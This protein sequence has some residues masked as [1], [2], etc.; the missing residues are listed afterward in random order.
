MA[1]EIRGV[2]RTA[3]VALNLW[4]GEKLMLQ[5]ASATVAKTWW[6][7]SS[8]VEHKN[9]GASI[10]APDKTIYHTGGG[11]PGGFDSHVTVTGIASIHYNMGNVKFDREDT[12]AGPTTSPT[13][14]FDQDNYYLS[15]TK[16]PFKKV[17][18]RGR[19]FN[20]ADDPPI[21]RCYLRVSSG[22]PYQSTMLHYLWPIGSQQTRQAGSK[23]ALATITINQRQ[24]AL[25]FTRFALAGLS[26]YPDNG[27]WYTNQFTIYDQYGNWGNFQAGKED[28]YRRITMSAVNALLDEG[29]SSSEA[30]TP[31][32]PEEAASIDPRK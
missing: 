7:S 13:H 24:G 11:G 12:K 6:V 29:L 31:I 20:P 21:E 1:P 28:N 32:S 22:S 5:A 27:G 26:L 17:E 30:F 9:I 15:S 19:F 18:V 3:V 14:S 4:G 2:N 8:R 23:R 16:Y 10:Q 25:C